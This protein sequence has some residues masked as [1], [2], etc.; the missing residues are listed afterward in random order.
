L[1]FRNSSQA[2]RNL[3]GLTTAHAISAQMAT[4]V[5]RE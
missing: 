4:S 5:V 1:K 2:Q 3:C